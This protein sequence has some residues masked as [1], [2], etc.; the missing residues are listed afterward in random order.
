MIAVFLVHMAIFLI[1]QPCRCF[2]SQAVGICATLC[3]ERRG[4]ISSSG[5]LPTLGHMMLNGRGPRVDQLSVVAIEFLQ[6]AL[7][8]EE[9]QYASRLVSGTWHRPD[10]T[11]NAKQVLR[12]YYLRGMIHLGCNDYI[13]AHRCFW[14][15]LCVPA[16]VACKT[17]IEALKKLVLVQCIMNDGCNKESNGLSLPKSTPTCIGRMITSATG[18]DSS[19][20]AT[21]AAHGQLQFPTNHSQNSNAFAAGSQTKEPEGKKEPADPE[22]LSCYIAIAN[23]FYTREKAKLEAL[24]EENQLTLKS[25]GNMGL[26]Q[27]CHT[28]LVHNQVRHLSKIYSVIS[29]EKLAALLS[30]T[31]PDTSSTQQH[32]SSLLVQSGVSCEI[33]EDGMIE[34]GEPITVAEPLTDL[35]DWISLQEEVQRLGV[36]VLTSTRY[37][38]LIKK[39]TV[40]SGGNPTGEALAGVA[41]ARPRGVDDL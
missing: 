22:R 6:C 10:S 40:S 14:T 37:Q 25:D 27:L 36:D 2:V 1:L 16:E 12:Y 18:G 19:L 38:S 35:A 15:C 11:V 4:A 8:A 5:I 7:V 41:A 39:E 24:V 13:I 32:V 28:Q 23:A 31:P 34:F 21:S 33:H 26:V 29:C 17:V 30:T 9:H 3:K 20:A